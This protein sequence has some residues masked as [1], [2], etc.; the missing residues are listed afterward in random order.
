MVGHING[1]GGGNEE[2][3]GF[4]FQPSLGVFNESNLRRYDLVLDELS[5]AMPLNHSPLTSVPWAACKTCRP[6][7]HVWGSGHCVYGWNCS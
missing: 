1:F 6:A 5:Q 3:S 4:P 2:R 7:A